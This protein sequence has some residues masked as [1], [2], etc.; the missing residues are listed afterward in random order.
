MQ[1]SLSSIL[2]TYKQGIP[3]GKEEFDLRT[4]NPSKY[5]DPRSMRLGTT[6]DAIVES[7]F[8]RTSAKGSHAGCVMIPHSTQG[9]APMGFSPETA[10]QQVFIDPE[11]NNKSIQVS[12][13][14]MREQPEF[15]ARTVKEARS[16]IANPADA[17]IMAY[18]QF[19]KITTPGYDPVEI[20]I[21]RGN[22]EMAGLGSDLPPLPD[23]VY[24]VS[25]KSVQ[26]AP[27][28]SGFSKQ[29]LS[30]PEP[31]RQSAQP[32]A[33][34]PSLGPPFP[35][36]PVIQIPEPVSTQLRSVKEMFE[37]ERPNP[38]QLQPL[39]N[40]T[41]IV[42]DLGELGDFTCSYHSILK[43]AVEGSPA[44]LVLVYD[45]NKP[46]QM[47]WFPPCR[48]VNGEPQQILALY[49]RV[50]YKLFATGI[51]FKDGSKEYCVLT[52]DQERSVSK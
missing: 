47:R 29:A 19:S 3:Q 14:D 11:L 35:P 24:V 36:P 43:T 13:K 18:G 4:P 23:N 50:A 27:Q 17:A 32:A 1:T 42:F 15:L 33:V 20:T 22:Q 30:V 10:V 6:G 38:I 16:T 26:V 37:E 9:G 48:E 25:N 41:S 12:I 46:M 7:L 45:H 49:E 8:N 31:S 52:I 21:Q 39:V 2:G 40:L 51:R 5:H 28:T 44:T 34:V